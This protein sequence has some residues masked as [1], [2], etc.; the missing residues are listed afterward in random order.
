MVNGCKHDHDRDHGDRSFGRTFDKPWNFSPA[1]NASEGRTTPGSASYLKEGKEAV[2]VN[3]FWC[4][5]RSLPVGNYQVDPVSIW[6][7][8]CK[9]NSYGRVEISCPAAATPM[10]VETPHPL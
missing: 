9:A 8:H 10:T 3:K 1:F 6:L 7:D 2:N 5:T 4:V